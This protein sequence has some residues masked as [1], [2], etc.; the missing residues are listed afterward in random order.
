MFE[1][2]YTQR[3]RAMQTE[4][5]NEDLLDLGTE[6]YK[7]PVDRM[8]YPQISS[9]CSARTL[10]GY[11]PDDQTRPPCAYRTFKCRQDESGGCTA[12]TVD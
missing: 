6:M 8:V 10:H 9:S 11:D 12:E 5:A 3:V 1:S 4:K 7:E 2:S